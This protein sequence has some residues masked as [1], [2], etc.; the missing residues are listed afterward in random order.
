MA[1]SVSNLLGIAIFCCLA[2]TAQVQP[3]LCGYDRWPVKILND[4]DRARLTSA[5]NVHR[6]GIH[7]E[8]NQRN[9]LL[10]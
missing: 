4:K 3:G 10:Q 8:Q 6:F 5:A 9:H 7:R 2:A 1:K